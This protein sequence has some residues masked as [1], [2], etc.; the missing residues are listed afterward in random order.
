MKQF[1]VAPARMYKFRNQTLNEFADDIHTGSR[2]T[3]N[4]LGYR[5][6]IEFELI[7]DT[8][9]V[10]GNTLTF[11]L[12][13]DIEKTFTG[14]L[15][16]E[17]TVP[18][19]NFA[20]GRHAHENSEQLELLK[21]ILSMVKPR[22]VIFQINNLNRVRIN[23]SYVNF[24]NSPEL[25]ME[26]FNKFYPELQ[27]VLNTTPHILLHWDDEVHGVDFSDCLIYNKYH[28]DSVDFFLNSEYKP[29]MGKMSHKLIAAK[30][31]KE[32]N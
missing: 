29:T 9:I 10:L 15:S 11:G 12:G 6:D 14:I 27:S 7:D 21:I 20:W 2:Y 19:Y 8:V 18:V 5:S 31:L 25:I 3:F 22:L 23:D 17:F 24:N 13:L 26:K 16:R 28:I 30:I 4:S 1:P 32:V